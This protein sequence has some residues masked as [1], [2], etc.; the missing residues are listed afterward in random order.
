MSTIYRYNF[1]N[2]FYIISANNISFRNRSHFNKNS[3]KL[4][5]LLLG[6][7]KS[8]MRNSITFEAISLYSFNQDISYIFTKKGRILLSIC[9]MSLMEFKYL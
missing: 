9:I 4:Q 1:N 8:S 5:R 7:K 3:K 6:E 2:F